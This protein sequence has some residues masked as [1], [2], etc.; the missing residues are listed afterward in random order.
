MGEG[1]REA[2]VREMPTQ[3]EVAGQKDGIERWPEPHRNGL[4]KFSKR[5]HLFPV[6]NLSSSV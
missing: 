3:V 6:T 4:I 1:Q 2:A 5:A